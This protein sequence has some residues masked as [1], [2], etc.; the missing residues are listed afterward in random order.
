MDIAE[1]ERKLM[2][3]R[4]VCNCGGQ[5]AD[6]EKIMCGYLADTQCMKC[7]KMRTINIFIEIVER[8]VV[9]YSAWWTLC[10]EC[11]LN[12]PGEY[13]DLLTEDVM[14]EFRSRS[15]PDDS[16]DRIFGTITPN[17]RKKKHCCY[18]LTDILFNKEFCYGVG[19]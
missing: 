17:W 7:E 15:K 10:T 5:V 6:M 3:G 9:D 4:G 19:G 2:E 8:G 18:M 16:D 11:Y 14:N 13:T 12:G 1:I